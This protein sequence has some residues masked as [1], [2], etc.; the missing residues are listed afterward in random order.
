MY[1]SILV[2]IVIFL[3]GCQPPPDEDQ[4][5]NIDIQ[6]LFEKTT[7]ALAIAQE[8]SEDAHLENVYIRYYEFGG[9]VRENSIQFNFESPSLGSEQLEVTCLDDGCNDNLKDNKTIASELGFVPLDPNEIKVDSLEVLQIAGRY[10]DI[11]LDGLQNSV[12]LS[13]GWSI[14]DEFWTWEIVNISRYSNG[15][16]YYKAVSINPMTGE[17]ISINE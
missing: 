1:A 17:L 4:S 7:L 5:V 13:L 12:N 3:A 11:K 14:K 15:S 6:S 10:M 8:W 16:R 2:L 9:D